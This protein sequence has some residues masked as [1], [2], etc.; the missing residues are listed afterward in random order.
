MGRRHKRYDFEL[1]LQVAVNA[2]NY[3]EAQLRIADVIEVLNTRFADVEVYRPI[4]GGPKR[5]PGNPRFV[6]FLERWVHLHKGV[7]GS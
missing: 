3:D 5:L 1:A 2:P 4:D 6:K 7:E